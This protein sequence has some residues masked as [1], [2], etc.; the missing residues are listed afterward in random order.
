[1]LNENIT[2]RNALLAQKVIKQVDAGTSH[3][4]ALEAAL[5]KL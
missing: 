3:K 2:K 5:R 1:M 4:T